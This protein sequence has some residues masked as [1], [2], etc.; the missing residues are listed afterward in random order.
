MVDP[1]KAQVV[2]IGMAL[3]TFAIRLL[4]LAM[5]TRLRVPSFIDTW[6]RYI[7]VAVLSAIVFQILFLREG[8][9]SFDWDR[10][11]AT[12]VSL[13][14]IVTTRNLILTVVG[15]VSVMLLTQLAATTLGGW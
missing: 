13:A 5:L 11:L 10:S 4:P 3:L 9:L 1:T 7:A 2:I 8:S 14:I 15:G 12:L 6:L